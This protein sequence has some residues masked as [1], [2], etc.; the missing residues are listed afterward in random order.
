MIF[1]ISHITLIGTKPLRIRSRKIDGIVT[2]YNGTRHLVLFGPEKYHGIY[3]RT[4]YLISQK[5]GITYVNSHNCARFKVDS[6]DPLPLE[7]T[8]T[9]YNII[10]L[11]KSFLNKDQ[12]QYCY[13]IFW[14][15]FFHQLGKK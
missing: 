14:E 12:N 4:R 3:N 2:I 9:L 7:K 13:N 8:L 10:I 6:C 5:I 1:D 11:I 15:E